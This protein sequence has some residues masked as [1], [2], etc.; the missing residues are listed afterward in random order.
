MREFVRAKEVKNYVMDEP[1]IPDSITFSVYQESS[2]KYDMKQRGKHFNKLY[3]QNAIF[4]AFQDT[5][6][7]WVGYSFF[8]L[9][10][11]VGV[12]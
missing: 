1:L 5:F 10:V 11:I 9:F 4:A 12:P 6:P 8:Y 3:Y 7:E 2:E